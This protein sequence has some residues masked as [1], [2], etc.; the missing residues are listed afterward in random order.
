MIPSRIQSLFLLLLLL[1]SPFVAADDPYK[2]DTPKS[3]TAKF[4]MTR[5]ERRLLELVNKERAKANLPALR[6]HPLLFK[7]A[8][9]HSANMAKQRK[10]E[11]DLDGKRPAQRVEAAGYDWGKVAENLVTSDQTD[12]PLQQIVKSWMDSKIHRENILLKDVTETGLGIATN[13]KDEVYYTQV[14]ARPRK[15]AKSGNK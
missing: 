12:V 11:H 15:R 5:D 14:F 2:K 8:R 3:E 13:A 1:A 7:A 10:M 9:D 6:P 4:E